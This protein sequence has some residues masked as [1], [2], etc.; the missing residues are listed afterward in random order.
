MK[1][2]MTR[3]PDGSRE[4]WEYDHQLVRLSLQGDEGAW[5]LLYREALPYAWSVVRTCNRENALSEYDME[6]IVQEA[7]VRCYERRADFEPRSQFRTWVCGFVQKIALEYK[8]GKYRI[9]IRQK[10]Y[11]YASEP[12]FPDPEWNCISRESD[13]CLWL[14]F[15][16]LTKRHRLLLSCYVLDWE[17]KQDVRQLLHTSY[18]KMWEEKDQAVGTFRGRY[19]SLYYGKEG[20]RKHGEAVH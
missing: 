9:L 4:K 19:L 6:D 18:R 2:E 5:E 12:S 8:R 17:K 11:S 10:R 3:I 13:F 20:G 7:F 1:R 14:A 15:D 16:S